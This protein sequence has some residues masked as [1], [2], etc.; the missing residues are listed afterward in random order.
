M[1]VKKDDELA[2]RIVLVG[3]PPGVVFA[4]QHG[5]AGASGKMELV[6]VQK[7]TGKDLAFPLGVRVVAAEAGAYDFRGPFV[8]GPRGVRFVY[9][10]SGTMAGQAGT[11]WTRRAK[12][13]LESIPAELVEKALAAPGN[14]LEARI[15]GT[16]RDGG[17]CCASVPL[18]EGGWRL[19][20]ERA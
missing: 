3:P 20:R 9:V 1:A 13:S 5:K 16:A 17:P 6:A 19:V 4:L 10:S 7:S 11:P 12:I 14:L 2:L 8:Q 15:A 18:L